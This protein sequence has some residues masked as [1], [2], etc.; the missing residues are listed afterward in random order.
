MNIKLLRDYKK[1]KKGDKVQV[2][3]KIGIDLI[4]NGIAIA[5]K[6]I[7]IQKEN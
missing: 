6:A 2:S 5:H 3:K 1:Y 7:Y 4:K